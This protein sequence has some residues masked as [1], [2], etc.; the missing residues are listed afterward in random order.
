[1]IVIY[2]THGSWLLPEDTSLYIN[3][4]SL[5]YIYIGVHT[6]IIYEYRFVRLCMLMLLSFVV[7][8][9]YTARTM[10]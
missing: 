9:N 3:I 5:V 1:M 10:R 7:R 2:N 6:R 8:I 4:Y